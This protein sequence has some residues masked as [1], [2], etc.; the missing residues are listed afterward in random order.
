MP[1]CNVARDACAHP[2]QYREVAGFRT[3]LLI[4]CVRCGATE[5]IAEA[6]TPEQMHMR[7][8]QQEMRSEAVTPDD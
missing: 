8:I 7:R 1:I 4:V 5:Q 3:W 2:E 6:V